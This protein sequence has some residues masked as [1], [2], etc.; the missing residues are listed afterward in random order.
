MG[1]P[2]TF[3]GAVLA[4]NVMP[5]LAPSTGARV[6][7]R[8]AHHLRSDAPIAVGFALDR[9]YSIYDFDKDLALAGLTVENRFATWDIRPWRP[10]SDFAVSVLWTTTGG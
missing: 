6:L 2:E 10:S 5:F 4:G 1:Y 9:G 8:V 7:G 3:D